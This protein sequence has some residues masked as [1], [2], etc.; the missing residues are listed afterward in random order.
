MLGVPGLIGAYHPSWVSEGAKNLYKTGWVVC[1]VVAVGVYYG[2]FLAFPRQ[3][4]PMEVGC[5]KKMDFEEL[6]ETE[7]YFPGE[8]VVGNQLR[9]FEGL[10]EHRLSSSGI[11]TVREATKTDV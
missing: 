9:T 11:E 8:Q 2:L 6:A 10:T 7:G 4:R 5:G 3:V 1:F